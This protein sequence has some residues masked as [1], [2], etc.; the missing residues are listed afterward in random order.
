MEE[1][2]LKEDAISYFKKIE[3]NELAYFYAL[4]DKESQTFIGTC[5]IT[6][7][8]KSGI[9]EGICDLGIMIGDKRYWGKGYG[10]E[11]ISI[12]AHIC[13]DKLQLRKITGGCYSNNTG[14][15]KAFLNN[16]FKIEGVLKN[17]L[18]YK[19]KYVDHI[20]FGCFLEDFVENE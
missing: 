9:K 2:I 17:Q 19:N 15:I 13:Y 8:S 4:H 12:M 6:L 11:A 5:K 7:L 10:S 16:G 18:K 3:E 1:I 20:L 14:M